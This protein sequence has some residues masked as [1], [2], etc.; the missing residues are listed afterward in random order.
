MRTILAYEV[1]DSQLKW[2]M[3]KEYSIKCKAR[4]PGM[5][6]DIYFDVAQWQRYIETRTDDL[7]VALGEGAVLIIHTSDMEEMLKLHRKTQM[8][9][10]EVQQD[11]EDLG[12]EIGEE[13]VSVLEHMID[14]PDI[15]TIDDMINTRDEVYRKLQ[16]IVSELEDEV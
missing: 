2:D 15:Y 8:N 9:V 10:N 5:H 12:K 13:L 3:S 4:I 7:I 6:N 1:S 11:C 16:K 14:R